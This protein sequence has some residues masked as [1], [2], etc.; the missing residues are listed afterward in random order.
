MID[1][2]ATR[3]LREY[4]S[5]LARMKGLGSNT[6][7]TY[8]GRLRR[9]LE[10][11]YSVADLRGGA[12]QLYHAHRAGGRLYDPKDNGYTRA[13]LLQLIHMNSYE[14]VGP[15]YWVAYDEGWT[16]FPYA[17]KHVHSYRIQ[18]DTVNITDSAGFTPCGSR[19]KHMTKQQL[20]SLI[21]L[22]ATIKTNF[23]L[24]KSDT[25]LFHGTHHSATVYSYR[26]GGQVG[27]NCA[28]LVDGKNP[29]ADSLRDEYN[30]MIAKLTA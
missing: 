25:A 20:W 4:E 13:A 23:C 29:I 3:F 30:R 7:R 28:L 17:D 27:H 10:A 1:A 16:S 14:E 6:I 26:I 12:E 21:W 15:D 18:W 8:S 9:F 5:F 19:V 24:A 11:D 2:E 22:L